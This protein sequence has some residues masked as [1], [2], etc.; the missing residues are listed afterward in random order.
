MHLVQAA[1]N[2]SALLA[3]SSVA[4]YGGFVATDAV[5]RVPNRSSTDGSLP[6]G[7]NL[8]A[9]FLGA[10]TCDGSRSSSLP[11]TLK[12]AFG[13]L[14]DSAAAVGARFSSIGIAIDWVPAVG[15]SWLKGVADFDEVIAG[16]NWA[17][18]GAIEYLW[19][20]S[21]AVPAMPQLMVVTRIIHAGSAR[22]VT[23]EPQVLLRLV[24]EGA[25]REWVKSH[26]NVSGGGKPTRQ[27][28]AV[29]GRQYAN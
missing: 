14:R 2:L 16:K 27:I 11:N 5:L 6:T 12:A 15:V 20:D 3:V 18:L 13:L 23:T 26:G 7:T 28:G 19:H 21:L 10:S 22:V 17:N 1:R 4:A 29:K 24:G 9:V 8:E 25:I